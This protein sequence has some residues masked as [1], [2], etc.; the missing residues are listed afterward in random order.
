MRAGLRATRLFDVL[1]ARDGRVWLA[2]E[3]GVNVLTPEYDRAAG[4]LAIPDWQTYTTSDGLPSDVA[5][6]LEEDD[7]GNVLGRHRGRP[8]A[9][10]CRRPRGPPPSPRGTA[11]SSTIA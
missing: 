10:R 8:G 11:S 3:D 7:A 1:A 9:H 5:N 6:A 2:A 4:T